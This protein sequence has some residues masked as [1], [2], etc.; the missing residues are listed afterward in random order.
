[1]E[2][3]RNQMEIIRNQMEIEVHDLEFERGFY[4]DRNHEDEER[5]RR[6]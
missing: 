6:V 2:Q 4:Y 3:M 1:M 5:P